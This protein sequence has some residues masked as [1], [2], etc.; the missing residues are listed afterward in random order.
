MIREHLPNMPVDARKLE[1]L[2]HAA[3][4][5]P[6]AERPAFIEDA[7]GSDAALRAELEALLENDDESTFM[8]S[9]PLR[10]C[11]AEDDRRDHLQPGAVIGSCRVSRLIGEGGMGA[12]Y[13]AVQER[14]GR[15][16]A[17]KIM[18]QG[19]A[20]REALRR[21]QYESRVLARLS[22]DGI[23]QVLEAGTHRDNG[24]ARPYFVMEYVTDARPVT[25]FASDRDLDP[26]ARLGLL[27]HICDAVHHA[28]QKGVIHRDLKPGNVLVDVNGRPR[29]IDF[30][31]ARAADPEYRRTTVR[32]DMGRLVGTI[33]YMSPEQV[34]EDSDAIDTR[35]DVYS[36]GVIAYELLAE[37]MPYDVRQRPIP[38]AVR[39]IRE[40]DPAPLSTVHRAF[41]GDIETIVAKALEKDRARRYQSA[42]DF[43]ADILRYLS[44]E[45]ILA[46]APGGMYQIWKFA[47]RNRALVA[48]IAVAI[49]GL[50]LGAATA[51]WQAVTAAQERNRAQVEAR[52]AERISAFLRDILQ[53][54]NPKAHGPDVT[55]RHVLDQAARDVDTQFGDDPLVEASIRNTI[56]NTYWTMGD[57]DSA[58][59]HL[60]ASYALYRDE[61]GESDP[62]TCRALGS[63]ADLLTFNC[64]YEEAGRLIDDALTAC[65]VDLP[66]SDPRVIE[67]M[68]RET[69]LLYE[70]DDPRC[71]AALR[72]MLDRLRSAYGDSHIALAETMDQLA[73]IASCAGRRDEAIGLRRDALEMKAALR[74]EDDPTVGHAYTDLAIERLRFAATDEDL[75]ESER[76]L[77]KALEILNA[78][79]PGDSLDVAITL[80]EFAALR[81]AQD[82]FDDA[83]RLY[84]EALAMKRRLLTDE[85]FE[86]AKTLRNL[87]GFYLR[88]GRLDDAEARAREAIQTGR[89]WLSDSHDIV[90]ESEAILAAI[91]Q[92]RD[93]PAFS[94][95]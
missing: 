83:E 61:L 11:G 73:V 81:M 65:R 46:R 7:C 64:Q 34:L 85:H 40:Q 13:E 75:L 44:D 45:P 94:V 2:F 69:T 32:T 19:L 31:V 35:S 25:E 68:R 42:N 74:G 37:R 33:P 92:A 49:V 43:S 59:A 15:V 9:P 86:V 41:R 18:R 10:I 88:I 56:G 1:D 17:I 3:L 71:E 39:I 8:A 67:L 89:K 14:T 28:H 60:L 21:F 16:V 87:A 82:D 78:A 12:V 24:A 54:A 50:T 38:E 6:G 51:T 63:L 36:L 90:R 84:L 95:P 57:L 27:A 30:G 80:A 47:R 79:F 4:D 70:Q 20:S 5:V 48:G 91:E 58:A 77:Q 23:A 55:V 52:R 53:T 93:D 66:E 29:V 22:H 26:R 76:L 62:A 72:D